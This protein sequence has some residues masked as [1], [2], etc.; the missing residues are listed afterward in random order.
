[1]YMVKDISNY[2]TGFYAFQQ[3]N[4]NDKIMNILLIY[5]SQS[6]IYFNLLKYI[7]KVIKINNHKI[8]AN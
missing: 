4:N 1:M 8:Q 5:H 2:L 6:K 7:R 3:E